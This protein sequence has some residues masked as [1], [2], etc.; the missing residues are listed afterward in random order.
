MG[1][2]WLQR[3]EVCHCVPLAGGG[4]VQ[5]PPPH[6]VGAAQERVVRGQLCQGCQTLQ[7]LHAAH[8]VPPPAQRHEG[9]RRTRGQGVFAPGFDGTPLG[10]DALGGVWRDGT[11]PCQRSLAQVLQGGGVV[12]LHGGGG[13]AHHGVHD[14]AGVQA[15]S[16]V[17]DGAAVVVHGLHETGQG[18]APHDLCHVAVRRQ[19]G[20]GVHEV[21][22]VQL[23][24]RQGQQ[25]MGVEHGAGGT[26][27]ECVCRG[28][29]GFT[30]LVAVR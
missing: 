22:A 14:C 10:H 6:G 30:L 16:H 3:Q 29:P 18:L 7:A 13:G 4:V 5:W 26:A 15:C 12:C 8:D 17:Q 20:Q 19:L 11:A 2:L 1:P 9:G 24:G 23:Q 27:C 28:Q 25:A 21:A